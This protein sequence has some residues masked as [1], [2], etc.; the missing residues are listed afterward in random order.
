M[1][2]SYGIESKDKFKAGKSIYDYPV[3]FDGNDMINSRK[4]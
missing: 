4:M 2:L 1:I 3:F